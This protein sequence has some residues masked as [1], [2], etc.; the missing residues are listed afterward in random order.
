MEAACRARGRALAAASPAAQPHGSGAVPA[1]WV[2]VS[3]MSDGRALLD[4]ASVVAKGNGVYAATLRTEFSPSRSTPAG[5]YDGMEMR[6]E[7]DCP[8]QRMRATAGKLQAG[9]RD[10]RAIP[11]P[12]SQSEWSTGR[13]LAVVD[14]VCRIAGA[15]PPP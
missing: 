4:S 11:V 9:G 10:L 2:L 15:T 5:L 6:L 13:G 8:G 14:V 3:Q 7:V 12:R 1:G